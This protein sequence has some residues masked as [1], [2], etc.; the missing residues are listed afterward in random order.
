MFEI[1]EEWKT[2]IQKT[3]DERWYPLAEGKAPLQH[4]A[5][6]NLADNKASDDDAGSCKYCII[7][8]LNAEGCHATPY[9]EWN[10]VGTAYLRDNL[11][12]EWGTQYSNPKVMAAAA[13]CVEYLE[14]LLKGGDPREL[15]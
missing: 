11:D 14:C 10:R 15:K 6:C 4:C 1:T 7:F 3:L 2:A 9:Q 8:K 5:L 13:K 12:A